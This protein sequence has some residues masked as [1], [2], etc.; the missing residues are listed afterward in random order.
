MAYTI[1]TTSLPDTFENVTFSGVVNIVPA[2]SNIAEPAI[3]SIT[4]SR[5]E[6]FTLGPNVD[7]NTSANTVT[8]SG[9]YNSN[10]ISGGIQFLDKDSKPQ[11]VLKFADVPSDFST[12]ISYAPSGVSTGVAT[13]TISVNGN[14]AG[15][16]T[17]TI[18]NNYSTGRDALV[19]LVAKGK[20]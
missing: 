9:Q 3:T 8:I 14:V 5:S 17:Q 15:S 13:Y 12:V 1:D 20:F 7:I 2:D 10:F 16:V 18:I 19:A 6:Q 11:T 4:V